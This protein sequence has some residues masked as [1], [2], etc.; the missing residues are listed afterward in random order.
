MSA[1]ELVRV[2]MDRCVCGAVHPPDGPD[3]T[4]YR[5][6]ASYLDSHVTGLCQACQDRTYLGVDPEDGRVLPIV[7][8]AV[9]AVRALATLTEL[10]LLPFRLVV[11]APTRAQLVLDAHRIIRAGPWLDALDL[12]HELDPMHDRLVGHQVC[13]TECSS[14]DDARVSERLSGAQLLLGL[15]R[16]S[17]A[18]VAA[19]CQI[20]SNASM[21]SLVAEIPW[22]ALFSRPLTPLQSWFGPEP[23]PISTVRSCAVTAALLTERG[24]TGTRPIDHL[25][26]ARARLFQEAPDDRA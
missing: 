24:R 15:D 1:S 4:A 6:Y 18:A 8:G 9:V 13:L 11:P 22:P 20:P 10:V 21:A 19:V 7:D 3:P 5:D 17:L 12:A 26:E 16:P 23:S 14:F 25:V 2:A